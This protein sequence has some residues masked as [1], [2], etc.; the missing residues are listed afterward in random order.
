MSKLPIL[1]HFLSVG[2]FQAKTRVIFQAKTQ[3]KLFSIELGP[4]RLLS[5][6]WA[7]PLQPWTTLPSPSA[8]QMGSMM[9]GST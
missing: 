2:K 6:P 5:T 7:Y 4:C 3:T 1:E 8:S 9:L